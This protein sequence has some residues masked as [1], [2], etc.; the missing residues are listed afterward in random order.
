[1][2]SRQKFQIN[3]AKL[4]WKRMDGLANPGRPER[5]N[6]VEFLN[7]LHSTVLLSFFYFCY[8]YEQ[9]VNWVALQMS[10]DKTFANSNLQKKMKLK[11]WGCF[12]VL[13][14]ETGL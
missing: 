5:W 14:V 4:D 11:S 12:C 2:T 6:S 3:W 7:V 9:C 13:H 1:M 10:M 8:F